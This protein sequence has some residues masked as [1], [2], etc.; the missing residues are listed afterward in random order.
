MAGGT[1]LPD[2]SIGRI[3]PG[4]IY[5]AAFSN[6]SALGKVPVKP[7]GDSA[8]MEH[9][10]VFEAALRDSGVATGTAPGL[11]TGQG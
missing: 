2:D 1:V 3:L 8:I 5:S 11:A 6:R 7:G 4:F 9:T 10:P